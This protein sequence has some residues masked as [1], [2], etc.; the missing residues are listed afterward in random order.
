MD[1]TS[2]HGG[3]KRQQIRQGSINFLLLVRNITKL[4]DRIELVIPK[5]RMFLFFDI[6][7]FWRENDVPTLAPKN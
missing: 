4:S 3:R 5:N 6:V 1:L 2:A 7:T